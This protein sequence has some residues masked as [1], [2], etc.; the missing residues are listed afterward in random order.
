MIDRMKLRSLL[1]GRLEENSEEERKYFS[2]H[3]LV[4]RQYRDFSLHAG[5]KIDNVQQNFMP[6]LCPLS[7]RPTNKFLINL[8]HPDSPLNKSSK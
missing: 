5:R 4:Q 1:W 2:V 7:T 6:M 3:E 8:T